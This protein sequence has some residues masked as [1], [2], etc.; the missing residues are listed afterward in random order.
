MQASPIIRRTDS[1]DEQFDEAYELAMLAERLNNRKSSIGRTSASKRS[2]KR[3]RRSSSPLE[4][5]IE[6]FGSIS[7][8]AGAKKTLRARLSSSIESSKKTL[9]RRTGRVSLTKKDAGNMPRRLSTLITRRATNARRTRTPTVA[10]RPIVDE[11]AGI[12]ALRGEARVI[13]FFDMYDPPRA[14]A[15]EAAQL[16]AFGGRSEA[17][18]WDA[19]QA[20][21]GVNQRRRLHSALK[22]QPGG[23]GRQTNAEDVD[24]VIAEAKAE[25][26]AEGRRGDAHS[27]VEAVIAEH[28]ELAKRALDAARSKAESRE[29]T[30]CKGNKNSY[31]QIPDQE[32]GD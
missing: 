6:G 7:P 32:L 15:Q 20:Q 23:K 19:L 1:K 18:M 26:A 4:Q 21:Y 3:S 8:A 25:E 10:S 31:Q 12:R 30:W 17:E 27:A 11:L 16:L 14:T 9:S 28:T 5:R 22:L 29:M 2:S 13:A 24:A